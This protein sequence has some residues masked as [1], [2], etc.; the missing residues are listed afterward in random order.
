[1]WGSVMQ[2]IFHCQ[3]IYRHYPKRYNIQ[4]QL[5]HITVVLIEFG[6]YYNE[7]NFDNSLGVKNVL[8]CVN[9]PAYQSYQLS[10]KST[11]KP[12]VIK[13]TIIF[14]K[15]TKVNKANKR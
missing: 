6:Y 10:D 7:D 1:M 13:V 11:N 2:S 8:R 12:T 3:T 5:T 14:L 4:N 9:L 15:Y